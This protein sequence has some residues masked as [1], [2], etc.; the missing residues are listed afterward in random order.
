MDRHLPLC[1]RRP[2]GPNLRAL[3]GACLL[4]AALAGG[5]ARPPAAVQAQEP[6]PWPH[7]TLDLY[8][9]GIQLAEPRPGLSAVLYRSGRV[10]AYAAS[11]PMSA[12]QSYLSLRPESGQ[13]DAVLRPG[14]RLELRLAG[15]RRSL[16]IPALAGIVD[17]E[18]GSIS[19]R[20]P[21]T[22]TLALENE[23]GHQ[24]PIPFDMDAQGRWKALIDGTKPFPNEAGLLWR[25]PG[26]DLTLRLW[27]RAASLM[28]GVGTQ[29][30]RL[31][32]SKGD[33][34]TLTLADLNGRLL[35]QAKGEVVGE[36]GLGSNDIRWKTGQGPDTWPPLRS[37]TQVTVL[38]EA[39]ELGQSQSLHAELPRLVV[40]IDAEQRVVSGVVGPHDRSFASASPVG[41]DSCR[42]DLEF[43]DPDPTD[44]SRVFTASLPPD[45]EPMP[46]LRAEI[47]LWDAN[48]TTY[49]ATAAI[50]RVTL[51][52]ATAGVEVVADSG[53]P[54]TVTWS[55]SDG[56]LLGRRSA[57]PDA[58][59]NARL[60]LRDNPNNPVPFDEGDRFE[61]D[62]GDEDP[63]SLSLPPLT[64]QTNAE[65]MVL[66]GKAPA[67]RNVVVGL[68]PR[69]DWRPFDGWPK[70]LTVDDEGLFALDLREAL[71]APNLEPGDAAGEVAIS[72]A[73]WAEVV[74]AW[75]PP[76]VQL[77]LQ[78]GGIWSIV[79][80]PCPYV[81]ELHAAGTNMPVGRLPQPSWLEAYDPSLVVWPGA[82]LDAW[83]QTVVPRAG[84]VLS[85]KACDEAVDLT[86]PRLEVTVDLAAGQVRLQAD[87]QQA[88]NLEVRRL[89][90]AGDQRNVRTDA[91]GLAT[92]DFKD[93][94]LQANDRVLVSVDND[95]GLEAF[96]EVVAHGLRVDLDSG[97]I[98]GQWLPGRTLALRWLRGDESLAT[99][100]VPTGIDG[101]LET[102]VPQAATLGGLRAG[103]RLS[104]AEGAAAP[105][106]LDI[107]EFTLRL[108]GSDQRKMDGRAPAGAQ[109]QL[110]AS[111]WLEKPDS[112]GV[113]LRPSW[114][115]GVADSQGRWSATL[116]R[117][118]TDR[119]T[120]LLSLPE[121]HVVT[122]SASRAVG[123]FQLGATAFC[124][125]SGQ[126]GG[127]VAAELRAADGRTLGSA[128]GKAG[129]DG[130]FWLP[131]KG[132]GG[133]PLVSAE[134][135]AARL[136][137]GGAETTV[138]LPRWQAQVDWQTGQVQGYGPPDQV[139]TFRR[140]DGV[141]PAPAPDAWSLAFQGEPAPEAQPRLVQAATSP[142]GWFQADLRPLLPPGAPEAK[143]LEATWS[144]APGL[145]LGAL[146]PR[147]QLRILSRGERLTVFSAPGFP[148]NLVLM[149]PGGQ[150]RATAS[151]IPDAAGWL[152]LGWRAPGG[153]PVSAAPGDRVLSSSLGGNQSGEGVV[154]PELNLDWSPGDAL[155]V[156]TA[157][158]QTVHLRL[159][160]A[161]G[162]EV[163]LS[164]D[165]DAEGR[166]LLD[167]SS[168]SGRN[169]WTMAAVRGVLAE[170]R[171]DERHSLIARVGQAPRDLP[172]PER[173]EQ[174]EPEGPPVTGGRVYLPRLEHPMRP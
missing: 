170:L 166:I 86:V 143:A 56:R 39:A 135:M 120:A 40:K 71:E 125:L 22:G 164:R 77:D 1:F 144:V 24:Q 94:P 114:K 146:L 36:G 30:L 117:D 49:S 46:G 76:L 107:P 105:L 163:A 104:L 141:C 89:G 57:R 31:S 35:A 55:S 38:A 73:D 133:G 65:T 106:L 51:L 28:I 116:E 16:T 161:D 126:G 153:E 80:T 152:G 14:D 4:L 158:N 148:Q 84:D 157:L 21:V 47:Y 5:A 34:L 171:L 147:E 63:R 154:L 66:S 29:D 78:G 115:G 100:D 25:P 103:D 172:P 160:L 90:S 23:N 69:E 102:Q 93:I 7:V 67:G 111:E 53:R 59:G 44:G 149:G 174:P 60:N 33:R 6:S 91:T 48:G 173:P 26:I 127:A 2:V 17:R 41:G 50:P 131:L 109:V 61:L 27:L 68:G 112:S 124:G 45:C 119:V 72:V 113:P 97:A 79:P 122:R 140:R 137:W 92:V 165:A 167:D 156:Q 15:E 70:T 101:R 162:R 151:G 134:G 99:W 155:T 85:L 110:L 88:V 75:G 150:P 168:L 8:G 19:G 145:H 108:D 128:G 132:E 54:I 10:Q 62:L 98:R 74:K 123:L 43:E 42:L 18:A 129:P 82:A 64:A 130:G 118:D 11:L 12:D 96:R 169:T 3:A 13:E 20:A 139:L 138:G 95:A 121:G 136:Q 83:G 159:V 9:N 81:G 58:S 32:T 142:S 37:G 87:P 52:P